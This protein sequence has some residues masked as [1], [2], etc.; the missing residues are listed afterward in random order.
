M[1]DEPSLIKALE[2]EW[3]DGAYLDALE[4]EPLPEDHA[5]WDMENVLL[6]PHD[7]HSS[8]YIGDRIV[9]QFCANLERYVR[10]EKLNNICD[11]GKGY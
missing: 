6:V 8:P 9:D 5:F 10:G 3:F 7:S 2:G 1:A 4:V 11:P